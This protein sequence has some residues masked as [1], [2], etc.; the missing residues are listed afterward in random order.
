MMQRQVSHMG[1]LID[2]LTEDRPRSYDAGFDAHLVKP[3]AP[4][5]LDELVRTMTGDRS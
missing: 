5:A 4:P 3:L 2:D 1:R